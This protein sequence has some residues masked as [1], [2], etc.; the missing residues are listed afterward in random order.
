MRN[1]PCVLERITVN[2]KPDESDYFLP[3]ILAMRGVTATVNAKRSGSVNFVAI[4]ASKKLPV[5]ESTRCR[6]KN[7]ATPSFSANA[8]T[9]SEYGS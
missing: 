4:H 2:R 1:G 5:F 7:S 3:K 8:T 9:L 6:S